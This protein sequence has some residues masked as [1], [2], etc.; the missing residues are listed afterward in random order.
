MRE[1]SLPSG[2]VL[3][4][5]PAPF[6]DSKNLYQAILRELPKYSLRSDGDNNLDLLNG[7]KDVTCGVLSSKEVEVCLWKCMERSTYNGLKIVF[8]T[9]EPEASREDFTEVCVEVAKDN[10]FPFWK[11]L[12]AKLKPLL[13]KSELKSQA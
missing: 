13:E 5:N 2:A 12:Y 1:V 4:I 7:L 6:A 3:K 11:N 8:D 10:V 9:F